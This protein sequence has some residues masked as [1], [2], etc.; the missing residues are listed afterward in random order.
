MKRAEVAQRLAY[1][2]IALALTSLALGA[3]PPHAQGEPPPFNEEDCVFEEGRTVCEAELSGAQTV[4]FTVRYV[5][6]SCID[7]YDLM[8]VEVVVARVVYYGTSHVIESQEVLDSE[9]ALQEVYSHSRC[10]S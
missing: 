10:S 3:P 2:L 1:I 9:P 6:G 5:N 4:L 7:Y 8:L